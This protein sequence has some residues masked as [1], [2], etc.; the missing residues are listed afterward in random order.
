MTYFILK[1][2]KSKECVDE[3]A[4]I[5]LHDLH[6]SRALLQFVDWVDDNI[7]TVAFMP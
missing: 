3:T 1:Y 7:D 2:L 6:R 4:I 5:E